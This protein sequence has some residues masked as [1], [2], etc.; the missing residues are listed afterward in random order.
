MSDRSP[1]QRMRFALAMLCAAGAFAS[2]SP[3]QP[4]ARGAAPGPTTRPGAGALRPVA[5]PD[6]PVTTPGRTNTAPARPTTRPVPDEPGDNEP[7]WETVLGRQAALD[8]AGF[9]PGLIDG[10]T[11]R[12]TALAVRTFQEARGLPPTGVFDA[13]TRAALRCDDTPATMTYTV[14]AADTQDVG[15]VPKDWNAKA[16][17]DRLRYEALGDLLAERGHCTRATLVRLNPGRDLDR[18]TPGA[19]VTLPNVKDAVAL[20]PAARLEVHLS[21]RLIRVLDAGDRPIALLHCSIAEFVE[22]RPRGEARVV[23]V[24]FDPGYTFKPEMWPEVK[25]VKQALS[26]PPGPRNPVGLCWIGLSLPGY[27]IHGTPHPELIGKTGSHGCIRLANWDA[28]RLGR[29]VRVGT[30]VRF[31]E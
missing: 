2:V 15:P 5:P 18:L 17:L 12:K 22:K 19:T 1:L 16:K 7:S 8:R 14:T 25:N 9:S 29:C 3:A 10:K 11:G 28:V 27:G 30:P 6:R 21:E 20:P 23:T 13:R 26:I 24:V 31:V 4:P